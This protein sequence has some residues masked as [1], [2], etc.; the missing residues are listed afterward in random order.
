MFPPLPLAIPWAK[1]NKLPQLY[2]SLLLLGAENDAVLGHTASAATMLDE[3]RVATGRRTMGGGRIGAAKLP[4][5]PGLLP[6]EEGQGRDCRRGD[7]H[8]IHGPRRCHCGSYWLFQ[9]GLAD[10]YVAH[11][12]AREAA[13]LYKDLLREPGPADWSTDP[14]ESLAVLWTPHPAPAGALV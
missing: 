9:I 3:A 10:A 8:G 12:T 1:A 11:A 6:A 2:V 14:M 13:D 5:R 7:G 4:R